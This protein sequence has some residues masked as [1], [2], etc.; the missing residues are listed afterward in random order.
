[1]KY[2]LFT[3]S[4][5]SMFIISSISWAQ[6]DRQGERQQRGR[7]Q[8]GPPQ[9]ALNACQNKQNWDSCQFEAPH[10]TISGTCQ[11]IRNQMAC[12]PEFGG[13]QNDSREMPHQRPQGKMSNNGRQPLQRQQ[14]T[15]TFAPYTEAHSV[16]STIVDT[17]Q[18][19]CYDTQEEITCPAERE[20][21]YGQ[22][23]HYECQSPAYQDN[24]DGTVTDLNTGLMWQQDPGDKMTYNEAVKRVSSFY[25]AGVF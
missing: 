4:L 3:I 10:G 24:G 6:P 23:A 11:T 8:D 12:V 9:Q 25:L 17:G 14:K 22:D 19:R 21:F 7:P 15:P 2:T 20:A 16:L 1:M 18:N 13:P 5:V